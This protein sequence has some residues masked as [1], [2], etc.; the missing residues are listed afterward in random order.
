M[1]VPQ[2]SI[3][4][5]LMYAVFIND[6]FNVTCSIKSVLYADDTVIILSAKSI[7]ELYTCAAY[8]FALY[9]KWFSINRLCLNDSKTHFMIF[10]LNDVHENLAST[11]FDNHVVHRV[12]EV[13]YLGIIIDDKLC[14]KPHINCIRDKLF[15]GVGMLKMYYSIFPRKCIQTIYYSYVTLSAIWY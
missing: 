14:W 13:R 4:R 8:Y 9:S 12:N 3:L 5:P 1:D 15:K 10:G 2:G 11:K 6:I 7:V